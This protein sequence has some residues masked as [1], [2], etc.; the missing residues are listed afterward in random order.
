MGEYVGVPRRV[1]APGRP[2]VSWALRESFGC[3]GADGVEEAEPVTSGRGDE[4]LAAQREEELETVAA[5]TVPRYGFSRRERERSREHGETFEEPS[6]VLAEQF[7]AP[8]DGGAKRLLPVVAALIDEQT[9][10][11]VEHA[12][13]RGH[14]EHAGMRRG[15]LDGQR[16]A[17]EEVADAGDVGG[18]VGGEAEARAPVRG[19]FHEQLHG[20]GPSDLIGARAVRIRERQ[21]RHRP[22]PFGCGPDRLPAGREKTKGLAPR[23]IGS[24][25]GRSAERTRSQVSRT[26]RPSSCCPSWATSAGI[27]SSLPAATSIAPATVV[28]TLSVLSPADR[29]AHQAELAVRTASWAASRVFPA[30]PG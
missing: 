12:Q 5:Q 15:Q 11:I 29:S 13:H 27:C 21:R 3:E 16:K 23:R 7:V 2:L 6:L 22:H 20:R 4:R 30:P 18:V 10:P 17:V 19:P 8:A 14:L 24:T 1:P 25:S 26:S 9:Q 28:T